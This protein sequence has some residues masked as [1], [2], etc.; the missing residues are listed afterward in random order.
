MIYAIYLM[1]K[2]DEMKI[3]TTHYGLCTVKKQKYQNNGNL[4]L[5]LVAE[6][7]CPVTNISTNIFAMGENEFCANIHNMGLTLWNDIL[8]SGL[9]ESTGEW[10]PSGY[11]DYPVYKVVG[12]ID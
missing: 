11:A 10:V 8:G 6:D 5:S 9:F 3:K 7:G 12:D 2:E 1:S 4:A